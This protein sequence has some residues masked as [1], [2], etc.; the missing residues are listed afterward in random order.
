MAS[1]SYLSF[2]IVS[3]H[4]NL[5]DFALRL[6]SLP[7]SLTL[8]VKLDL[9]CTL[10]KL[11]LFL[12]ILYHLQNFYWNRISF[13]GQNPHQFLLI[14]LLLDYVVLSDKAK[15][16]F[17]NLVRSEFCTVPHWFNWL[18]PQQR[19][20]EFTFLKSLNFL[21]LVVLSYVKFNNSSGKIRHPIWR[22]LQEREFWIFSG[23]TSSYGTSLFFRMLRNSGPHGF[24]PPIQ[25][26]PLTISSWHCHQSKFSPR[27][28]N[29]MK[30]KSCIV[31]LKCN[32]DRNNKEEGSVVRRDQQ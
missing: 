26:V 31:N 8:R 10:I 21:A 3:R 6:D 22:V 9:I 14:Q 13:W 7:N 18:K 23:I 27:T 32:W 12:I 2:Y 28:W 16:D 19:S 30:N 15:Q 29:R 11:F 1:Y 20:N 25:L 17:Q 24:H 4:I 5:Q